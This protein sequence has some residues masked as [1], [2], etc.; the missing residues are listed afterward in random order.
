MPFIVWDDLYNTGVPA[1][2]DQHKKIISMANR[3]L[4]S[5]MQQKATR[6]IPFI[7]KEMSDY[8][9]AHFATEERFMETS[10]FIGIKGHKEQHQEFRDKVARFQQKLEAND[11]SLTAELTIFL[12]TWVTEHFSMIDHQ[13]VPAMK[14]A[15]LTV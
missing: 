3:M 7:L 14:A 13:Y 11:P 10:G 8:A 4:E 12:T 9:E 6:E 2:D 5:L 15:G 1:I